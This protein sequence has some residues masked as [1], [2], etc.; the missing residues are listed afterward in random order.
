MQP[1][2]RATSQP[3]TEAE[4]ALSD[5]EWMVLEGARQLKA[6]PALPA[7]TQLAGEP[8]LRA[9]GHVGLFED[10]DRRW[11]TRAPSRSLVDVLDG[12]RS[13]TA[14]LGQLTRAD[15]AALLYRSARLITPGTG[16][17]G[18]PWSHRPAPSAGATHPF[19]VLVCARSVEGLLRGT[20]SSRPT[21]C[22]FFRLPA[23]RCHLLTRSKL[24]RL[25]QRGGRPLR[26]PR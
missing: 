23:T 19:D 2:E 20:T 21:A 9:A 10:G 15:L 17:D 3:A 11:A 4:R 24:R 6:R 13:E 8:A 14:A 22:N 18:G 12:R 7:V 26:R 5:E 16:E 25:Q 1:L